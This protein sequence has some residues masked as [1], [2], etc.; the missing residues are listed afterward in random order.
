MEENRSRTIYWTQLWSVK[1][2][3]ATGLSAQISRSS[4]QV[5]LLG[6]CLLFVVFFFIFM[7]FFYFVCLFVCF[8]IV[9]LSFTQFVSGFLYFNVTSGAL[10]P[11]RSTAHREGRRISFV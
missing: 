11:R 9:A 8:L 6:C 3:L 5:M 7:F 4:G 1:H 10:I 2:E